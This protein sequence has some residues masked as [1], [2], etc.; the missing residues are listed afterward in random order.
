MAC[1]PPADWTITPHNSA[2][3]RDLRATPVMSIDPPVRKYYVIS[4]SI[5]FYY[6]CVCVCVCV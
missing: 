4:Y 2:G 6:K 5:L 1:L 3:R